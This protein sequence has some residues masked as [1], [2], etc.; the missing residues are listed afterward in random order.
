MD[1]VAIFYDLISGFLVAIDVAAPSLGQNIGKWLMRRLPRPDDTVN[2]L[3]ARTFLLNLFL[4]LL[5]LSIL[6]SF[7]ISK[8]TSAG[9]T[10]Q[11][12]TVG[13]FV[14]GVIIGVLVISMLSLAILWL[15]RA[16]TR[17]HG[18]ITFVLD[19]PIFS[20]HTS[21]Q[22]ATLLGVIWSFFLILGTLALLLLR[23]A[24]GTR[25]FLAA[26]ILTF[27]LTVWVLPTAML[28]NR[29]FTNYVAA[30][31][32]KPYYALARIGL[33]IFVISKIIY[34]II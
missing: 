6:V 20:S 13:L 22:D 9:A 27:V 2:P 30:N 28:W 5:P 8:D 34:L 14:L 32:E 29:S 23:F 16:Y 33:L 1:K 21:A 15:R 19:T 10:F 18:T 4:T 26:P 31:P 3:R 7:A 25:V 12:S 24:T 11:W 17:R